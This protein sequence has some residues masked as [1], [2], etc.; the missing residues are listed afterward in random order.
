MPPILD[1]ASPSSPF[2]APMAWQPG[3]VWR[4]YVWVIAL[5]FG[6][7]SQIMLQLEGGVHIRGERR[8]QGRPTVHLWCHAAPSG[9]VTA[10]HNLLAD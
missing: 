7:C 5:A 10:N 2:I 6:S 1:V 3:V 8:I 9:T 4:G